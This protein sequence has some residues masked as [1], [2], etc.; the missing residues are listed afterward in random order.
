MIDWRKDRV[1]N[2]RKYVVI[3]LSIIITLAALLILLLKFSF[4][5]SISPNDLSF[6]INTLAVTIAGFAFL[7]AGYIAYVQENTNIELSRLESKYQYLDRCLDMFYYP[8]LVLLLSN[9]NDDEFLLELKKI[10]CYRY[11][12]KDDLLREFDVFC[13]EYFETKHLPANKYIELLSC[14]EK[15]IFCLN[16][17]LREL[18]NKESIPESYILNFYKNSRINDIDHSNLKKQEINSKICDQ[19][20]R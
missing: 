12:A 20:N 6:Y 7:Y 10:S 18:Y 4:L 13:N 15:R 2:T 16:N 9:K 14:V 5:V 17:T 3:I 8:L 19:L 1:K 11:L